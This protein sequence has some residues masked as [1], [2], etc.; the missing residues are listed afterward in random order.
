MEKKFIDLS[1]EIKCSR[2]NKFSIKE[3]DIKGL[4]SD[5]PSANGFL[6]ALMTSDLHE[7]PF[8]CFVH[9]GKVIPRN[10]SSKTLKPYRTESDFF[11]HLNY[12]WGDVL[13]ND[14]LIDKLID[15]KKI[16]LKN[17]LWWQNLPYEPL[18]FSNSNIRN[19][20][21]AEALH[22]LRHRLDEKYG[23]GGARREGFLHQCILQFCLNKSGYKTISNLI[24][25]PD[26]RTQIN[27]DL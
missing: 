4:S 19:I 1:L 14:S 20:K 12:L 11:S 13:L 15:L 22:T 3:R 17:I 6:A 26:L 16:D 7:G 5:N 25:V 21:V 18:D 24:G 2:R 23:K 8:W 27:S 9:A 10:Y